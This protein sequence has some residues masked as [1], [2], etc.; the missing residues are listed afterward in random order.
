MARFWTVPWGRGTVFVPL[1]FALLASCAW[2]DHGQ[3]HYVESV[4]K[5]R[6][7]TTL[8][9]FLDTSTQYCELTHRAMAM[10]VIDDT[11]EALMP[12]LFAQIE[13]LEGQ[14]AANNVDLVYVGLEDGRFLAYDNTSMGRWRLAGD[15]TMCEWN[16][17]MRHTETCR[18]TDGPY[19]SCTPVPNTT[20]IP[21]TGLGV[22]LYYSTSVSRQ[23]KLD[24]VRKIDDSYDPRVR[25]WY[26]NEMARYDDA[27]A[28]ALCILD[29]VS[30]RFGCGRLQVR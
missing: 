4:L 28:C 14:T 10:G 1:C 3:S 12:W 18:W 30:S 8:R 21:P 27:Y 15:S 22:V 29:R 23:G 19:I 17:T 9:A 7:L 11:S 25:V 6:V 5:P 20:I 13:N 24:N 2:G 26:K 16:S